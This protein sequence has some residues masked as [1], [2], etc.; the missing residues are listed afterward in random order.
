MAGTM[1]ESQ[2]NVFLACYDR[3]THSVMVIVTANG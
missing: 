2:G 1:R 3:G